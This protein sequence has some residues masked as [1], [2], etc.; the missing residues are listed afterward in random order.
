MKPTLKP[1]GTQPLKLKH[2]KLLS[3]FTFKFNLRRYTGVVIYTRAMQEMTRQAGA[4]TRSL[5]QLNLSR[6]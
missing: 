3:S 2:G 6:F 5:F 1:P 4:Y